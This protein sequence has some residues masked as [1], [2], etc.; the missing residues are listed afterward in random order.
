MMFYTVYKTVNLI[1]GKFYFGAHKTVNP[2]DDYLGSGVYIKRAVAKYGKENFRKEVLFVY[3]DPESA[4]GK[5]DELICCYRRL[6]PLCMNLRKG[7]SGGFDWINSKHDQSWRVRAARKTNRS[8]ALKKSSSANYAEMDKSRRAEHFQ[9]IRTE[10]H[11]ERARALGRSWSGRNHRLETR[12]AISAAA[13]RRTGS[14]NNQFGTRW[15]N[16]E[17]IVQKVR[18][19]KTQEF[20]KQGWVFGRMV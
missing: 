8:V 12:L 3:L 15:M 2:N 5:E 1:N 11:R 7:G 10:T 19:E 13:R 4:F 16:K 9:Y 20:L 17:G 18:A 14:K 6:D